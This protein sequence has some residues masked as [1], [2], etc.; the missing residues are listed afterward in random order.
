MRIKNLTKAFAAAALLGATAL[1]APVAAQEQKTITG[2]FDV[3]PG[4]FQG[5]FNPLAATGG[6]TWLNVYFEPLV[7][8]N[9][10]L[11]AIEGALATEYAISTE[12]TE[13]T[14]KLA[15]E[16]WHDGKPFTAKDVKF[17]INLAKNGE[18][19]TVFAARLNAI[20]TAETPDDRTVVIKLSRPDAGLLATLTKLM[21]LPEHALSGFTPKELATSTWW[22]STPVGTGPFKFKQYVADQY[23]ELTADDDYRLGRPKV[24]RVI[25]R[26]FKNTAASVAAL[27]AGEIQFT[28]VESDDVSTFKG[29][30]AVRVIEG[31]SFV[32]NYMG[33]NQQVP[34]WKDVRIR[35]AIMYAIDR[36]SIIDSLYN[37]AATVA[38]CG[39]VAKHLVPE[40]LNPYK[41]DPAKA[42]ALLAEAGWD[43]INGAKPITWLTYYNTPQAANVMAA[44][45]AMLAQVGINVVPRVVDTPT[46]NGII[47]AANPDFG[48]FPLV[49][50]GLQNGPDPSG[51]NIG[52]NAAQKPP[53]G[54]N[55]LRVDMPVLTKAFDAALGE[56][57]P[58]KLSARYQDVCK[59]MNAELPWATMWVANRYGVAST[60]LKDFVW[61][62]APAGGPYNAHPE[63][64]SIEK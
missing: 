51:L 6:F 48:Q 18:T 50:A 3:G 62:P 12:Q 26:Y 63:K 35:Q 53:A 25:N 1:T 22:A 5:N 19:G 7:N 40:G 9:A 38:N 45:Q 52:L 60:K 30:N 39:Y 14:F 17:T 49:Y 2:G 32:A 21:I 42:K 59:A 10:G 64:W 58:Q 20:S 27:R 23:V 37:G 41:Y 44:V 4:G 57:D 56:T 29:N 61:V 33:F 15:E 47:Y 46:Y 8:Y 28:Y 54:A 11:T 55:F 34:L 16:T 31:Q 36:Q 24:D 43:K 13:Y